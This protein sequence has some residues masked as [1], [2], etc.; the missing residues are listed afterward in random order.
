M[1]NI[2]VVTGSVR[3]PNNVNS[4]VVP[5]VTRIVEE[6]GHKAIVADLG[7]LNM[8]F[9][10]APT[11]AKAP[12]FEPEYE[13]VKQWTKMVDEADGVI[14]VMPEY[15]HAMSPIQLNAID[16]IGKEWQDKPVTFVSYGASSGGGLAQS[17][18]R[19]ALT[20]LLKA[21]VS[22]DVAN[23]YID[24]E[25]AGDGTALDQPSIDGKITEAVDG[26]IKLIP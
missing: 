23:I 7:K 22:D 3:K 9:Y 14:L 20:V 4:H 19:E 18:A 24:R 5:M 17:V 15:N 12:G 6:K 26:L 16:W 10:D 13:S 8:P 1:A 2:L 21:R 25:I 11:P